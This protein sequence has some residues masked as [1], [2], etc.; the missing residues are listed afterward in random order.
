M[1]S[2]KARFLQEFFLELDRS[3]VLYCVL[4]N[5]AGLPEQVG[6]DVDFLVH[7]E[8]LPLFQRI[9]HEICLSSGWHLV[10]SVNRFNFHSWRLVYLEKPLRVLHIDA[11]TQI[12][13]K[14]IVYAD[15]EVILNT[16]RRYKDFWVASAGSE[17]AVSILKEYLRFGKVKDKG[18]GKTKERIARSAIEDPENFL[19]ALQPC[20]GG[21]VSQLLLTCAKTADWV[22]LEEQHRRARQSLILRALQ[23][24]PLQQIRS[25]LGFL[26]G[27]FSDHVLYP[28][29]LFVCLIGP[30]GAGKSTMASEIHQDMADLFEEVYY[31][32]G[33]WG[34]LPEL[35][36]YYGALLNLLGIKIGASDSEET[37][38]DQ[39]DPPFGLIQALLYVFY[40]SID[41]LLGYVLV[42]RYRGSGD[43]V[44]F[45]RYFYDYMI[46]D[47]YSRVPRWLLHMIGSLIPSPDMLF[48]LQNKPEVIHQ[49]KQELSISGIREQLETCERIVSR[50]GRGAHVIWTDDEPDITSDLIEMRIVEYM[51]GRAGTE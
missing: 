20:L 24:H 10:R 31:Y 11:W 51:S 49:R 19:L 29:G 15:E 18:K 6:H 38:S 9:L 8:D 1:M 48:L 27:H 34:I 14:G 37:S 3:F 42:L 21:D 46:Q 23:R 44:L 50:H 2:Y 22:R 17:A 30:D 45:D 16:R 41:Y 35:K 28:S 39:V 32:H 40:Y 5:Y 43:L 4:R 33:H 13:W 7:Q 26:W 12:A 36:D 25:W 47:N